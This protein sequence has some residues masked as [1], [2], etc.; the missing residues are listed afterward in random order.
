MK[1]A[2]RILIIFAISLLF[3]FATYFFSKYRMFFNNYV[4]FIYPKEFKIEKQLSTHNEEVL[5]IYKIENKEVRQ[6]DRSS[7]Y[8]YIPKNNSDE[9]KE[10]SNVSRKEFVHMI[11]P[12]TI[13]GHKGQIITYHLNEQLPGDR[14][15]QAT[16]THAFISSRYVDNPLKF[17]YTRYD[18]DHSLDEAYKIFLNTLKY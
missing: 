18:A 14:L 7:I 9:V 13:S 4:F 16:I 3:I 17:L 5:D 12:I 1:K 2:V 6:Y 10:L 11:K 15:V 8:F